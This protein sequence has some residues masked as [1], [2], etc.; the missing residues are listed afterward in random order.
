MTRIRAS[1]AAALAVVVFLGLMLS[2]LAG[3]ALMHT[4][5]G[6]AAWLRDQGVRGGAL[7]ILFE[8]GLTLVGIV[9]GAL[10]GVLAGGIFG[11]TGGF[12]TSSIGIM[13]GAMAAFGLSR[14]M[15]RGWIAEMLGNRR[16]LNLL[17]DKIA[18]QG[19]LIVALLR[20][21]P[22]MP[23]SVTSYALGLSGISARDYA[24][25]TAASLLPLLGYVVIGALG[26]LT[27]Q[28]HSAGGDRVRL[29]LLCLGGAATLVLTLVLTR[30]L[31]RVLKAA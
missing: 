31:T 26:G 1:A 25:G 10:L 4:G 14:T 5:L 16:R 29:V 2:V 21:S 28:L 18:R 8:F 11:I 24:L 7:F 23:F 22:V 6:E 27:V 13:A 9:P 19:W 17:D 3:P 30:M 20:I 15:F 12:I